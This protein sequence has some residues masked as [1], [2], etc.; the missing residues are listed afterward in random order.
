MIETHNWTRQKQGFTLGTIVVS[1]LA[2]AS[3]TKAIGRT[4]SND[5]LGF[6]T[7]E[8]HVTLEYATDEEAQR[9]TVRVAPLPDDARLSFGTRWD[10]S[11]D[12]HVAKAKMLNA[13]GVKGTFYLIG[14]SKNLSTL[15]CSLRDLGHVVGNHTMTHPHVLQLS[16]NAFFRQVL[17][18]RMRL[19]TAVDRT[20]N[21]YVGPFGWQWNC[22]DVTQAPLYARILVETGHYVSGDNPNKK[23][24]LPHDVWYPAYRFSADDHNPSAKRFRRESA[25]MMK[26]ALADPLS[27]RL[28]LGTHSW[29]D[30]A[31][32]EI[33]RQELVRLCEGQEWVQQSD[34]EYGAYRYEALGANVRKTGVKGRTAT[35]AVTRT[36]PSSL[37]ADVPLSLIVEPTPVRGLEA[38]RRGT[39]RLPHEPGRTIVTTVDTAMADGTSK[40]FG[41]LKLSVRVRPDSNEGEIVLVNEGTEPLASGTVVFYAP[42]VWK[43]H[44]HTETFRELAPGKSFRKSFPLGDRDRA[45]YVEDAA[46]VVGSVDFAM[47]RGF[48]RLWATNQM[49]GC[50]LTCPSPRDASLSSRFLAE[51]LDGA[52]IEAASKAGAPLP[53]GLE[54]KNGLPK[55]AGV[56]C[57]V[58]ASSKRTPKEQ[59]EAKHPWTRYFVWDFSAK[60]DGK[61]RFYS[62]VAGGWSVNG[63]SGTFENAE[64]EVDVHAGANRIVV[65]DTRQLSSYLPMLVLRKDGD[66]L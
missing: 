4:S 58:I 39:W 55:G 18:T 13:A 17:E 61:I 35:F 51:P 2:F 53:D 3:T 10:D 65:W 57:F 62:N 34:W 16:P 50:G 33:Q 15:A 63:R 20:I 43:S 28:T 9:A 14:G 37:A 60:R 45:D 19:E 42:P 5:I 29:C 49:A 48:G 44:R 64:A 52:T 27:P 24:C 7:Y 54:W 31:G 47:G 1:L 11:N 6:P 32:N 26:E 30:D 59:Q 46:F 22:A 25:R 40:K 36:V 8:Q 56:G 38:G 21:S 12:R 66:C 41:G 23:I